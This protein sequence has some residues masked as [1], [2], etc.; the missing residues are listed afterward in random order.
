MASQTRAIASVNVFEPNSPG[1]PSET[2]RSKWPTHRQ[3]TPGNAAIASAFSTPFRRLD[4]AEERAAAVCGDELVHDSAGP[5]AIVR[6]LQGD[7][8]PAI[9]RVLHRFEDVAGF[10]NVADHRQHQALGAHVHRASDVMIFLR[11]NAHDHRQIGSLEIADRAL[12]CLE[13]K[14]GMLE[15][16]EHE[17]ATGRFENMADPGRRELDDEMPELWDLGLSQFLQ[18]LRC[19][20]FLPYLAAQG[21]FL[22]L[23]STRATA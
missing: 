7:A 2:E 12:H 6:D 14:S 22:S 4:L 20:A 5:I 17:V 11:R 19:H 18:A 1:T 10:V 15:I 23:T 9:G 13:T 16:E 8:P 3:S 21:V